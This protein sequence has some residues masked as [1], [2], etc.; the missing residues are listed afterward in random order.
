MPPKPPVRVPAAA[1]PPPEPTRSSTTDGV[2][3]GDDFDFPTDYVPPVAQPSRGVENH[4]LK[5]SL[6][7]APSDAG[8]HSYLL[9]S[10]RVVFV[11]VHVIF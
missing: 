7:G 4:E 6:L 5:V 3:G 2:T 11:C 9:S 10:L 8:E 1:P